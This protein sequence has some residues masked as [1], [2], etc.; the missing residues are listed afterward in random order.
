MC[1][2]CP[3]RQST[4]KRIHHP[5]WEFV[6][7]PRRSLWSTLWAR[8]SLDWVT[9]VCRTHTAPP[10]SLSPS[11]HTVKLDFGIELRVP[12]AA[13]TETFNRF[14]NQ[15]EKNT[16]GRMNERYVGIF[17]FFIDCLLTPFRSLNHNFF[18]ALVL[19]SHSQLTSV[20]V[21]LLRP[22]PLPL[23]LPPITVLWF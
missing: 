18:F 17:Y 6:M 3:Q 13:A 9:V 1:G 21:M 5:Y 2:V 11:G 22:S 20:S 7:L 14:G 15:R 19:P 4:L 8:C 16:H 12:A 23:S 10:L